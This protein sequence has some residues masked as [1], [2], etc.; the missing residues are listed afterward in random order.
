MADHLASSISWKLSPTTK[1]T[2]SRSRRWGFVLPTSRDAHIDGVLFS[3]DD[4]L[5]WEKNSDLSRLLPQ[6]PGVEP[7]VI[8]ECCLFS[9]RTLYAHPP[10]PQKSSDEPVRS[11]QRRASHS[12]STSTLKVTLTCNVTFATVY[13]GELS[14]EEVVGLRIDCPDEVLKKSIFN[15]HVGSSPR[16]DDIS[17]FLR[18][19]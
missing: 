15:P 14:R 4:S 8:T 13:D 19:P 6:I 16:L 3:Q 7:H 2:L 17:G 11:L 12:L 1:W 18:L 10:S 9:V 5:Y